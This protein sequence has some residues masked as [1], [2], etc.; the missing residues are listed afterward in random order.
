LFQIAAERFDDGS[1]I[2]TAPLEKWPGN[3]VPPPLAG[4]HAVT[5]SVVSHGQMSMVNALLKDMEKHSFKHI[6]S[7]ILTKNL[8]EPDPSP[9]ALPLTIISNHKPKG[10][11][12]N[13]NQ[14]FQHCNSE[15]FTVIN[16]DIR[17]RTDPFAGLVSALQTE[18]SG[19]VAPKVV[20]PDGV[21]VDH[22]RRLPTPMRLAAR[23]L[24]AE[25][26]LPAESAEWVAGMF[27]LFRS[28]VYQS[29]RGFDEGFR[30]YCEDVD[31]C[32]RLRLGGFAFS[33]VG[34][35]IVEHDAQRESRR[36]LRYF[37]WHLRSMLRLWS[38]PEFSQYRA[39][40]KNER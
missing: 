13:H 23:K 26:P 7:V 5:V 34:E 2:S 12:E 11:A 39:L 20:S 37:A 15:V 40:L 29:L 1:M 10:F 22:L 31:I 8:P 16:P 25:H 19:M 17:F 38:K 9:T 18:K 24:R 3:A 36:S 33:L 28:S 21:Q 32:M 6:H 4:N 14:A 30:L 35:C 27:M